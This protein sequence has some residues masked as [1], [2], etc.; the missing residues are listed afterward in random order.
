MNGLTRISLVFCAFA[1]CVAGAIGAYRSSADIPEL[2]P[3]DLSD[4]GD[5]YE[6]VASSQHR[7][8]TF[9]RFEELIRKDALAKSHRGRIEFGSVRMQKTTAEVEVLFF[10]SSGRMTPVV[11]KFVA[12]KD[13]W[14]VAGVQRIWFVPRSHLLRGL[15]V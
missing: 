6:R 15:R 1:L 10:N 2:S 3:E 7:Q 13:S 9:N 5:A 12:E 4:V 8:S 14:R 11:Y